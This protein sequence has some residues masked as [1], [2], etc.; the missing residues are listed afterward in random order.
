MKRAHLG[1]RA[2]I[3]LFFKM[4]KP[5]VDTVQVSFW[6]S[7]GLGGELVSGTFRLG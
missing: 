3:S 4:L 2:G 1:Q 5:P 6:H 7:Y